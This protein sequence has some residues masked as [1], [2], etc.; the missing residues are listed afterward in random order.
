V[1]VLEVGAVAPAAGGVDELSGWFD[2]NDLS[3][4]IGQLTN[5]RRSGAMRGQIDNPKII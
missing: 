2:L 4:P 1:Q 5:R 3:A